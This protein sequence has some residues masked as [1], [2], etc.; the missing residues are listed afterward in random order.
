MEKLLSFIF[1][2]FTF[3]V[4]SQSKLEFGITTDG[5]L[6]IPSKTYEYSMDNKMGFG[7][8]IGVYASRTI[9]GRLSADIGLIYRY[10]EMQQHYS[11]FLSTDEFGGFGENMEPG[12]NGYM[13]QP[14][15]GWKKYPLHN[16]VIPLHLQLLLGNTFFIRGG[17]EE[18]FL[19]NFDKGNNKP[20]YSWT[21]GFGS[22]K[23]RLKWSLNYIR[24]FKDEGFLNEVYV[25]HDSQNTYKSVT[26]F[27]NNMIQ[28]SLS[29]PIWKL[30]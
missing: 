5:S 9:Y 14:V 24:G 17:V 25:W 12:E 21:A 30:K 20:D 18:S 22:Q 28:L 13:A 27:R 15:T 2:C 19:L 4:F 26:S 10:K 8:G 3:T 16:L 1:I 29:Y 11:Y 7:T 6:F 23:H